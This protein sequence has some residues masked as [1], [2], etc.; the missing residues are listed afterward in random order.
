METLA[1]IAPFAIAGSILPTWTIV[2][3]ALLGTARPVANASAFIAGNAVFRIALGVTVLFVVPLPDSDSFRLDSGV[4]DARVVLSI[5]VGLLAL[6]GWV[7]T[8]TNDSAEKT[9]VDRAERIGPGTAF[10]AG[11]V[12][13]ASP[14]V[15]YAYLLGGVAAI[16]ESGGGATGVLALVAFV[17]ALQW[18]LALPIVIYLAFRER[19]EHVL[20]RMK[21]FL[22]RHG[23][24]IVAAV[25]GVAGGY[26]AVLG[27]TQ[28]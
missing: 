27:I 1:A 15:Q 28:L 20:S 17:V 18:M 23:N 19:S 4:L 12:A 11:L 10:I 8:R 7:W 13:V 9:W 14:G 2:V 6:A 5:G 16:L 25:L 26:V 21:G 3:I 22:R 24:R